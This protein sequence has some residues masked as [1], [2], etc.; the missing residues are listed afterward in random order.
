[1]RGRLTFLCEY[2]QKQGGEFSKNPQKTLILFGAV[3]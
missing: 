1:M 3:Y 2:H